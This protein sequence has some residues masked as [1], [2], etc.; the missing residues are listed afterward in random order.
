MSAKAINSD[1][2]CL[3]KSETQLPE[4][5]LPVS[6]CCLECDKEDSRQRGGYVKQTTPSEFWPEVIEFQCGFCGARLRAETKYAKWVYN[7]QFK[8]HLRLHSLFLVTPKQ[9]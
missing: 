9:W 3:M 2:K 4:D 8:S 7:G 5:Q 1:L 6:F